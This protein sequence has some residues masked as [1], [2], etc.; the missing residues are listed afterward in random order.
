[1]PRTVTV[2][3]VDDVID[4]GDIAYTIVTA[5]GSQRAIASYNGLNAADVAVINVDNDAAGRHGEPGRGP[6]RPARR[7]AP[8][9]SRWC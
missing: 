1:M 6:G 8:P 5:A 2:T 7:A 3:G 4:D 9:R